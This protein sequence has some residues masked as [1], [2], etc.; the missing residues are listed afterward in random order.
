MRKNLPASLDRLSAQILLT[1]IVVAPLC[2]SATAGDTYTIRE[3]LHADQKVTD[4]MTYDY[5]V[6]ST[7]TTNGVPT[8]TDTETGQSWKLTLTI[9]EVRN[10]S[11]V[12]S[13][14]EVDSGSFDTA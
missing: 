8:V 10:G 13:L 14:A 3:S 6:K 4:T 2:R 7:S 5:K 1:L 9:Q 12:R 11:S